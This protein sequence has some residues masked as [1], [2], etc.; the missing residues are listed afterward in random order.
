[1][2]L[3]D[4][5]R[6][7]DA[8]EAKPPAS[9]GG[10]MPVGSLTSAEMRNELAVLLGLREGEELPDGE[11]LLRDLE[12]RLRLLPPDEGPEVRRR[13]LFGDSP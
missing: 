1:V 3:H 11:E 5:L 4:L 12:A 6:R 2:K 7:L 10:L 9:S 13:P 8:V